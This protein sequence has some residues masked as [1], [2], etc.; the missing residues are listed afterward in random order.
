MQVL[1]T[2]SLILRTDSLTLQTNAT[3]TPHVDVLEPSR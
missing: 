3:K 1:C 2:H